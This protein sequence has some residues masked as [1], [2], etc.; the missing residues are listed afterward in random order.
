MNYPKA[1]K[2]ALFAA[3]LACAAGSANA[4]ISLVSWEES[5]LSLKAEWSVDSVGGFGGTITHDGEFW[6]IFALS[7]SSGS[8]SVFGSAFPVWGVVVE[9]EHAHE[10]HEG[11]FGSIFMTMQTGVFGATT[12]YSAMAPH[13]AGVTFAPPADWTTPHWDHYRLTIVSDGGGSTAHI[14]LNAIHPVPEPESSA[15]LLAGLG[16]MAAVVRRRRR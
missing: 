10:V 16:L 14:F 13:Q 6:D 9:A 8:A 7:A 4:G 12:T 2:G 5:L 11:V 15:M 1:M 3:T